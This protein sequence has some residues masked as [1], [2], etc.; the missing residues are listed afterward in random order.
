MTHTHTITHTHTLRRVLF[1]R[2]AKLSTLCAN[3]F[4]AP[5]LPLAVPYSSR[6]LPLFSLYN[7]LPLSSLS[8]LLSLFPS[9]PLSSSVTL[10]LSL[11]S[12]RLILTLAH[13][14]KSNLSARRYTAVSH[15]YAHTQA[16]T[17]T[18]TH[19]PTLSHS[20]TCTARDAR[21]LPHTTIART[22][23]W[24]TSVKFALIICKLSVCC[25][26]LSYVR[27]CACVCAWI[28]CVCIYTI[29]ILYRFIYAAFKSA[30]R[31][32]LSRLF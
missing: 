24:A 20:H 28:I 26:T 23:R 11:L 19:T 9:S 15:R 32:A 18:H 5:K 3:F 25:D 12:T 10:S 7:Y 17:S 14:C 8:L 29:Y 22:R 31:V 21:A 4:C 1:L 6:P 13:S 30:S 2:T 27:V 16:L